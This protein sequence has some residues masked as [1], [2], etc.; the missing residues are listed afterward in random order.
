MSLDKELTSKMT[1]MNTKLLNDI[2]QA[3]DKEL[4]VDLE[5][6]LDKYREEVVSIRKKVKAFNTNNEN[7]KGTT[8]VLPEWNFQ[9][10]K[11]EEKKKEEKKEGYFG[12]FKIRYEDVNQDDKS[13]IDDD[14]LTED[15][16]EDSETDDDDESDDEKIVLDDSSPLKSSADNQKTS[17]DQGDLS[18]G[19]QTLTDSRKCSSIRQ[20][21][22]RKRLVV[23]ES[24]K[25]TN[26]RVSAFPA[27]LNL[28]V[29]NQ[30]KKLQSNLSN[31]LKVFGEGVVMNTRKFK[32]RRMSIDNEIVKD[33][34]N[35]DPQKRKLPWGSVFILM[36]VNQVTRNILI[37]NK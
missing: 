19:D 23:V 4:S 25:K 9:A 11:N 21:A 33:L 31:T 22:N 24:P 29:Q 8:F 3:L 5:E 32:F 28:S 10:P 12:G 26:K 34:S 14:L 7:K 18:T 35:L 37:T 17:G 27:S 2:T 36:K 1:Q 30:M 13:D 16:S 20:V 6:L 15:E